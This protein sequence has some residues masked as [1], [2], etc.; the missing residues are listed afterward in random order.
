MIVTGQFAY[1]KLTDPIH[2]D[3][4]S[5]DRLKNYGVHKKCDKCAGYVLEEKKYHGHWLD[6]CQIIFLK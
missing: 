4:A 1:K 2:H 5:V 3:N 6:S